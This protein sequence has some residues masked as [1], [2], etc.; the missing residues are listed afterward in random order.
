MPYTVRAGKSKVS[1]H[2]KKSSAKRTAAALRRAGRKRVRVSK[3]KS[4]R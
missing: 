4:C 1:C 3:V 2:R